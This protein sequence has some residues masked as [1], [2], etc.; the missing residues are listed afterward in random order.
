M[1]QNPASPL[2]PPKERRRLRE[3]KALTQAQVAARVGVTRETVRS[4]ESGRTQPRGRTLEAYAELLGAP[5]AEAP[6]TTAVRA[7]RTGARRS[8]APPT[9]PKSAP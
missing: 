1:P 9:H 5:R 3:S 6:G 4:W 2:P 8:S 7:T